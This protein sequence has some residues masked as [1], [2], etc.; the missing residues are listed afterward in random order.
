MIGKL[1]GFIDSTFTDYVIID[2]GGVGYK[3]FTSAK[4]I[5]Y[6][7]AKDK[8]EVSLLI[9][10]QIREDDISLYGFLNKEEKFWFSKMISVKGISP[11][12]SL[13]IFSHLD[14]KEIETAIIT[15]DNVAFHNIS[16]VGK[17]LSERI[18]TELK[19]TKYLNTN[20]ESIIHN[21]SKVN[22]TNI[23]HDAVSALSNL[24]Y[25]NSKAYTIC[26]NGLKNNPDLTVGELIKYGLKEISK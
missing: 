19:D 7:S 18:I 13:L 17:K 6:L 23:L 22:D 9:D 5:D 16:G 10:T 2:V 11:R 24:G 21:N 3:V 12:I 26:N 25:N 4:T 1:R 8:E 15:K 14:S 20:A